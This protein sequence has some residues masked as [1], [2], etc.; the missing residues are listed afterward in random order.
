MEDG[1]NT[2]FLLYENKSQRTIF[3]LL[4]DVPWSNRKSTGLG[5]SPGLSSAN[6]EGHLIS[7]I[8][9]SQ[10]PNGNSDTFS[11]ELF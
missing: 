3:S 1:G 4:G 11:P 2:G 6:G 9:V 5:S 10:V 8:S 7:L